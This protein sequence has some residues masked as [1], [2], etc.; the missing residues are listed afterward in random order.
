MVVVVVALAVVVVQVVVVTPEE[1]ECLAADHAVVAPRLDGHHGPGHVQRYPGK[2]DLYK[3]G[4]LDLFYRSYLF[5]LAC[6]SARGRGGG[7]RT[8]PWG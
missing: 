7:R 8:W 3:N 6:C 2:L 5:T 1:V 4:Q